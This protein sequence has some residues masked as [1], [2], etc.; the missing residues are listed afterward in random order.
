[1]DR[2]N[3]MLDYTTADIL[4]TPIGRG[5]VLPLVEYP[6]RAEFDPDAGLFGSIAR[7]VTAPG[8]A[9]RG[10]ISDDEMIGD[11]AE[12]AGVFG[13]LGAMGGL[14]SALPS[15]NSVRNHMMS[16]YKS[17]GPKD[18]PADALSVSRMAGHDRYILDGRSGNVFDNKMLS[19][20]PHQI[21]I[22]D[23]LESAANYNSRFYVP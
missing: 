1:M 2:R 20:H 15:G 12:F 5:A 16:A 10:E 3:S 11:G 9:Y 7:A 14:R 4:N 22:D 17:L 23:L 18:A 8:R 6:N 19:Q 21:T 13:T